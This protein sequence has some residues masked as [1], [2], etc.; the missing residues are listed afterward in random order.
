MF[1]THYP[2]APALL[3]PVEPALMALKVWASD[4]LTDPNYPEGHSGPAFIE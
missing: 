1:H 3:Q 4:V 2:E